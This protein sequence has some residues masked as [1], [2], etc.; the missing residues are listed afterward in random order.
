MQQVLL[1]FIFKYQYNWNKILLALKNQEPINDQE[2]DEAKKLVESNFITILDPNYPEFLKEVAKPP[3]VLFYKGQLELLKLKSNIFAIIVDPEID[4]YAKKSIFKIVNKLIKQ[5]KIIALKFEHG[6]TLELINYIVSKK[7]KLILLSSYGL[8]NLSQNHLKIY[9]L[10]ETYSNVILISDNQ[11]KQTDSCLTKLFDNSLKILLTISRATIL[12]QSN[13]LQQ[14]QQILEISKTNDL[15]LF[16]IPERINSKFKA[17]NFAIQNG[18][19]LA[20]SLE[21]ILDH[22]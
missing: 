14:T 18:A 9:Q 17:N 5:Q 21:F 12:C 3:L 6:F 8:I 10:T 15:K 7:G 19:M 22:T 2:L 13:N 11:I 1:Y 16:A 4:S 20:E